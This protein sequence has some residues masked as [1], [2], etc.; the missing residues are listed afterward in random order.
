MYLS[1]QT[2]I[3]LPKRTLLYVKVTRHAHLSFW[4][5]NNGA[6]DENGALVL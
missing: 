5:E 3:Q 2:V 4:Y 1:S 6:E